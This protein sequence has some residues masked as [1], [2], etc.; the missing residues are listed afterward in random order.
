MLRQVILEAKT[1]LGIRAAEIIVRGLGIQKWD[2]KNLKG[3]C[4]F[5][6]EKTPSFIWNKKENYFKCFGC[7]KTLDIIDYYQQTGMNF[8]EAA[9]ELFRE[10]NVFYEFETSNLPI[11]NKS[12]KPYVYPVEEKNIDT[13]QIEKYLSLRKISKKTIAYAGVKEDKQ[14]NVVFEY[15]NH[16]GTLMLVKYRP[17]RK[18]NDGENKTWCQK[19]KDTAPIL[20]GMEKIDPSKPLLICEGEIDRLSAIEAGYYNAV[21]VPFGANNYTWIEYNW[22]WLDQFEKII[23]WSDADEAGERMRKE[24]IPRLGE[25]RCYYVKGK[26]KDI[27]LQLYK[28]GPE[29]ILISIDEAKDVPISGVIDMADVEDYDI[30]AAEKIKSGINGLDKWI[31]GFVLGTV[32][33]ITGINGSGKSTF[34]DQVCVVEAIAQGYKTFIFSG[35]LT[36]PQLRSWI[37]YPM[38]GPE[39]VREKYN[40][41]NEPMSYYIT[42]HIKEK[43]RN[44]YKGK[45]YI[46]DDEDNQ[47]ASAI[48][49][50]MEELAR[51][52][53][54]KNFILDNLMMIDLECSE[55]EKLTKQKEFMN[56]LI[57]FARRFNC[58]I[59]LVAHPRK[60]ET[61]QR[62]TKLD[63]AGT[64]DIINMAHY[65][66]SIHRVSPKEKE[67]K[68]DKQG[69]LKEKGCPYDC[70]IDLF[71]NRPIG[72]Q[73]KSI[74]VYFERKSKRFYGDSDA[75]DKA[76]GWQNSEIQGFI[77]IDNLD[78]K[79]PWDE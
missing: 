14:G 71:K 43:M 29:S 21:S 41:P 40:G 20:Y 73:D 26:R 64:G 53:G 24:V 4:P 32:N 75:V 34:I 39:N 28:D 54:V 50:K 37:E 60:T 76:Y 27:N 35:E 68:F 66:I 38:A 12:N 25:Y 6:S 7:G 65:I 79:Y 67:D 48:L 33:V 63:V 77:E 62:L 30:G 17:A 18:L 5:H 57:K 78:E 70:I 3:I 46:Y 74:G 45:V 9:K 31:S 16:N 58:V 44:W 11:L 2:T 72:H 42:K 61:I 52:H 55:Y 15:R 23:I 36:K 19:D 13:A 69:D 1:T 56:S 59:H 8:T 10:A 49:K 22:D 51:K 47:K